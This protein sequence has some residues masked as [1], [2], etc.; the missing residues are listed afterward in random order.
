MATYVGTTG[1]NVVAT[2]QTT[3][4]VDIDLSTATN[5]SAYLQAPNGTETT[6]TPSTSGGVATFSLDNRIPLPGTYLVQVEFTLAGWTG[7]TSTGSF[8]I[9]A[10]WT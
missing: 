5:V 7:R 10:R 4:G 6:I 1:K 2:A 3:A 8:T 9:L